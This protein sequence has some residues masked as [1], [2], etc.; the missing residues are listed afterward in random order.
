MTLQVRIK[1]SA[2]VGL[3]SAMLVD[4]GEAR[5]LAA[6]PQ[7][8]GVL[9]DRGTGWQPTPL[10]EF[11]LAKPT[12][13][14]MISIGH[15]NLQNRTAP[16]RVDDLVPDEFVDVALTL[17]P[18]RYR[19]PAGHQLGVIVYGTDFEMTVRGNQDIRYTIDVEQSQ[20]IVPL[21]DNTQK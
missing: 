11:Q 17:Q 3:V 2:D 20:L 4:Y 8:Q 18:T 7:P 5:R 12:T 19:L 9:I 21:Q 14:K 13:E 6:T 10:V 1:S 16:W 15:I